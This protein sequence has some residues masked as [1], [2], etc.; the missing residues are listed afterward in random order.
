MAV[1]QILGY[2]RVSSVGQNQ[3]RQLDGVQVDRMFTDSISGKNVER[4][5]LQELL[6]FCRDGDTVV[7]HSLDRLARNLDD[8]RRLVSD[9]TGR[10][11]QVQFM[12]E[13][14]T[15]TGEDSSM[16]KLLLSVMGAFAEFERSLILERQAEGISLAKTRGVYKGRKPSL[17]ETQAAELVARVAAGE[18]K[19]A[20]ARSLGVSRE[21]VYAYLK[22]APQP[23]PA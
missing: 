7:V 21:T 23:V 8:L 17:D 14:L 6:A 1:G 4:P 22:R 12:K 10:G 15:F 20:I 11:V 19:A 13:G 18:P 3:G 2:Q 16:S 5:Q 9:L